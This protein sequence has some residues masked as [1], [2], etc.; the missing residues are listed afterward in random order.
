MRS[1]R[2]WLSQAKLRSTTHRHRPSPLPCS[3]LRLASHGTKTA[4]IELPSTPAQDQS[5]VSERASQS[6]AAK[7]IS[8]QIPASCQSRSRRQQVMPEPQ[9]SFCGS[10][11]QGIPLRNTNMMPARHTRSAKR[12][13]PP[14]RL[15]VG[16]RL[17]FM[18]ATA[19]STCSGFLMPTN[20]P[21]HLRVTQHELQGPDWVIVPRCQPEPVSTVRTRAAAKSKLET[22]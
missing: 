15:I 1:R 4:L 21:S 10:I 5:I 9:P 2:N 13:L 22:N 8:C 20:A 16:P 14:L 12:G 6:K 11:F 17:G 7:W 18:I 19:W 3:V